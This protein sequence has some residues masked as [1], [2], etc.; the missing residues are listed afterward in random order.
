MEQTKKWL[1]RVLTIFTTA[2]ITFLMSVVILADKSDNND[3]S[4]FKT[5]ASKYYILNEIVEK[6]DKKYVEEIDEEK[7]IEGAAKGMVDAVGDEYTAYISKEDAESFE[8]AIMGSFD[9]IGVYIGADTENNQIVVIAPIEGSPADKEGIKPNDIIIKVDD[10]EYNADSMDLAV[11][12]IKGLPGTKV[13]LT[14][15][16][17]NEII[18]KEVTRQTVKITHVETDVLNNNIGYVSLSSFDQGSSTEFKDKVN[19]LIDEEKVKGLIIDLRSNPGGILD[20]VVAIADYLLPDCEIVSTLN[21]EGKKIIYKSSDT[22]SIDLPII[23]LTNE[24]SASASEILAGAIKDNNKGK[25]VGKTTFGKGTV[26]EVISLSDGSILKVTTS[27]YYT[28]SGEEI[29]KVGIA[30]DVEVDISKEYENS[31]DIPQN[32]DTQL[33]KA[34]E[35]INKM[36]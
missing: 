32:K 9:G 5:D 33:K 13:K 22:Q 17:D 28:P 25:I 19:K 8:T 23:I 1:E 3:V 36:K 10:V 21:N 20:E 4:I 24:N 11:S 30:P 16:R 18:E 7:L 29:N 12:K 15:K 27:K 6:L 14:I 31:L 34:I 26:Q 2:V 35:E